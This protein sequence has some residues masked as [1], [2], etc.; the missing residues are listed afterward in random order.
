MLQQALRIQKNDFRRKY[1]IKREFQP[2]GR[3]GEDCSF[4]Q[5]ARRNWK[6]HAGRD[7]GIADSKDDK[8]HCS[9]I[10]DT[11]YAQFVRW[12]LEWTVSRMKTV[13]APNWVR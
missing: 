4:H 9:V 13:K 10:R 11:K 2:P 6:A 8:I 12:T 1:F 5:R 7:A 3:T